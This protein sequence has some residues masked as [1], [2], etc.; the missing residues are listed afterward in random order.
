MERSFWRLTFDRIRGSG[1]TERSMS[2]FVMPCVQTSL[3]SKMQMQRNAQYSCSSS[4]NMLGCPISSSIHPISNNST[5]GGTSHFQSSPR[6]SIMNP[7]QTDHASFVKDEVFD[8]QISLQPPSVATTSSAHL[9]TPSSTPTTQRKN[10]RI[11]NLFQ[12]PKDHGHDDKSHRS[13]AEISMGMGRAIPVKQGHLY[14]RSSKTLNKEW[15]KKYV[16]LHS[17]GR[18]SYHQTLKD[19]MEKDANGKEVFLGLATVRV[20]GRQRPRNTLRIQTQVIPGCSRDCQTVK[21]VGCKKELLDSTIIRHTF[22]TASTSDTNVSTGQDNKA[23]TDEQCTN[24]EGT[25]GGSD[26]QQQNVQ[27]LSTSTSS[28]VVSTPVAIT[29]NANDDC[30]FEIVTCDQK[31]WEFSATSVEE[32]DEWVAAIEELIEKSLQA[33]MSQKQQDSSRGH[34]NKTEVQALRQIPGNDSCADCDAPKP[35]WAS[36]NLGTLICIECSG[37]HRN[38][39]SHI[40]KVR[41]LDLDDWPMEYLNVMEA[42]GNKKANAIWEYSAPSGRKPQAGSSREEKEKWIKVKYE[43]KRFLPPI[44][45]D[46][47]LGRQLLNAVFNNDLDALL[48][49]LPRCNT[50]DLRITVDATDRRTALHIACSNASA[51]CTQLL[52]WYNAD[53][54]MLDEMG[55]SALWHAQTS[56]ALDCAAILLKAGLDPKY[57]I[58]DGPEMITGSLSSREFC[59]TNDKLLANDAKLQRQSEVVMRRIIP[60]QQLTGTPSNV[61]GFHRRNSDAFERLPASVI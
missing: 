22:G 29:P 5:S 28:F 1:G 40:S 10:R 41:S 38:L 2:A 57:G 25:S 13:A 6:S 45:I 33:Q 15:K 53:L 4:N 59:Y 11:S 18:L 17:N 27:P 60:G 19:Y 43:G 31:R 9:L 50:S 12:R 51:A 46:E 34:G 55:R 30:E 21:D 56:G 47:P 52:V 36:L 42:I 44:A 23:F 61:N 8:N 7:G 24:G 14:K 16:C 32:R 49:I 3:L 35:D 48:P 39:G 58:P 20:A 54:R 37:I 26:D